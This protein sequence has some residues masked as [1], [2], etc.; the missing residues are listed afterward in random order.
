VTSYYTPA[1]LRLVGTTNELICDARRLWVA[2]AWVEVPCR[3]EVIF[4]WLHS[5]HGDGESRVCEAYQDA[6]AAAGY[7][8]SPRPSVEHAVYRDGD[9]VWRL[10]D[11]A[12]LMR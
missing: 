8:A 12:L 5:G 3:G 2:D 6:V 10:R 9:G 1:S 11:D 4:T 7:A